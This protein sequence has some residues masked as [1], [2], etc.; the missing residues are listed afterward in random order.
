M[1][2]ITHIAFDADD[3]L[4]VNEPYFRASEERFARMLSGYADPSL[5]Q[6]KLFA[7]EMDNLAVYGYGVKGFILSMIETIK[8]MVE[9]PEALD[10]IDE[11]IKIGRAQLKQPIVL[12]DDVEEVLKSLSDRYTLVLATKGDL[13]EQENKIHKSGLQSYF[14]HIEVMSNKKA[15]NYQTLYNRLHVQAHHLCMVGNSVKSDILPVIES[16]G[17]AIHIPFHTTWEHEEVDEG[18]ITHAFLKMDSI[19][20]VKEHFIG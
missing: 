19:L 8:E 11:A 16:G 4:W 12:L 10:F 7:T 15:A 20:Q 18:S 3:T 5:V 2:Q 14:S 13:M 9:G 17:Q 6:K 1:N